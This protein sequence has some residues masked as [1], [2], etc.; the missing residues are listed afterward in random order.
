[1]PGLYVS[2]RTHNGCG[3][4]VGSCGADG[5]V[6]VDSVSDFVGGAAVF[7][8]GV[9]VVAF[10]L[11]NWTAGF[12]SS[13]HSKTE[14]GHVWGREQVVENCIGYY[15]LFVVRKTAEQ[16]LLQQQLF[17]STQELR[18][19]QIP[20]SKIYSIFQ[21]CGQWTHRVESSALNLTPRFEISSC[22]DRW[23]DLSVRV[24]NVTLRQL[25]LGVRYFYPAGIYWKWN[26][27]PDVYIDILRLSIIYTL[28]IVFFVKKNF[29]QF[30]I[31]MIE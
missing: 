2:F 7:V 23:W 1:M 3:L 4:S 21:V 10:V 24:R 8:W 14:V 13:T 31:I 17:Y 9:F 11:L 15:L 26:I 27:R 22:P 18:L 16:Q 28:V 25:R 19:Y 5:D 6:L 12:L 29:L 30:L 20:A